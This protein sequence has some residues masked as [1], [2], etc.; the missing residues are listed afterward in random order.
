VA[1]FNSDGIVTSAGAVTKWRNTAPGRDQRAYFDGVNDSISTPD[2]ADMALTGAV[3][4]WTLYGV[5]AVDFTPTSSNILCS[6]W[7]DA[8]QREWLFWVFTNGR[9]SFYM[10]LDGGTI[11]A[12]TSTIAPTFTDGG[13]YD[14]KVERVA[15]TGVVTFYT[16][17]MGGTFVQLCVPVAST[18]GTIFNGTA[19][20]QLGVVA[21]AS[22]PYNGRLKSFTLHDDDRLAAYWSADDYTNYTATTMTSGGVTWTLNSGAIIRDEYDMDVL[23]G[24]GGLRRHDSGALL[25]DGVSGSYAYTPDSVAASITGDITMIAYAALDDWTPPV[26]DRTLVAKWEDTQLSY[27]FRVDI[28]TGKLE[29]ITSANPPNVISQST[30][31]TG[32]TDGTGHW[33]R[34]TVNLAANT[35]NFYTSEDA[36]TTAYSDITW[37]LLGDADVA[38]VQTAIYNGTA[39]V[40]IG[41]LTDAGTTD[42]V[43]GQIYR[44]A[45]IAGLDPTATPAVDFNPALAGRNAGSGDTFVS[46]DGATYTLA[47]DAKIQNSGRAE[48]RAKGVGG[49]ET[50]V[51]PANVP[52]PMT[53][54][55]V[56]KA[57][58]LNGGAFFVSRDNPSAGPYMQVT[59]TQFQFNAGT[60]IVGGTSDTDSHLHIARHNG[61]ATTSYQIDSNTAVVGNAGTEE[62]NFGTFFASVSGT[63]SY[64]TGSMGRFVLFDSALS[65]ADVKLIRERLLLEHG[66]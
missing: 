25:L 37:T 27:M 31:A 21:S 51:A 45:V 63:V 17:P 61:D 9:V 19:A 22:A 14:I 12:A 59:A 52:V 54:F 46:T 28:N 3:Q 65:D 1:N 29:V 44:A 5:S 50:T 34:A 33:V 10:S 55:M 56:G 39:R 64:I 15:S 16:A 43:N 11:N 7:V 57:D 66:I 41:A 47:G 49:I 48:V 32:F 42:M 6:K 62:Y 58:L 35:A 36:P 38:H 53:I 26:D 23:L 30:V 8:V 2:N 13:S 20:L 24:T 18:A 60:N 40:T 4:T